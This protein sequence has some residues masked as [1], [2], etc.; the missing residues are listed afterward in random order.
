MRKLFQST[1][2]NIHSV[3]AGVLD[4]QKLRGWLLALLLIAMII[5]PSYKL[6]PSISACVLTSL[7]SRIIIFGKIDL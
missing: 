4:N 7:F 3:I 1:M 2:D 5:K 6:T